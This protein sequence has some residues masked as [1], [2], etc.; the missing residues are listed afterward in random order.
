[1]GQLLVILWI[2]VMKKILRT[3]VAV[4]AVLLVA[5]CDVSTPSQMN[6]TQIELHRTVKTSTVDVLKPTVGQAEI[7]AKSYKNNGSGAVTIT[8][9][10]KAGS[11]A[12]ERAVRQ[13]S[14]IW[15]QHLLNNG[16]RSV[17]IA[18]VPVSDPA[19][20][21]K[22]V[23]SWTA[24]VAKAPSGCALRIPGYKG[25]DNIQYAREY[26]VGCETQSS[27]ARQISNPNDLLGRA[28]TPADDGKRGGQT[29][30]DYR[31]GVPNEPM[32]GAGASAIGSAAGG[33]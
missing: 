30:D 12:D 6:L 5:G 2:N 11:G 18:A 29:V 16:V 17:E 33:G 13:A 20:Q 8:A 22:A 3:S 10:Y 21:D 9:A 19:H 31:N 28:G 23:I 15:R 4:F 1:M 24:T 14:A 26:H 25:A 7:L 27:M 32:V